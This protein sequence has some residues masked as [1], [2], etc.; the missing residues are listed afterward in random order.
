MIVHGTDEE[1]GADEPR[2]RPCWD[3]KPSPATLKLTD[4]MLG[5]L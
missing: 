5:Q 3:N 4:E 2:D 1:D